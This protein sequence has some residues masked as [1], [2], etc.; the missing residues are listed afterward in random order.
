MTVYPEIESWDEFYP[1]EIFVFL[2]ENETPMDA[3]S[4]LKKANIGATIY[5]ASNPLSTIILKKVG[6]SNGIFLDKASNLILLGVI[7]GE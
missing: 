7:T 6:E 5:L 3:E 1:S 2:G 4:V